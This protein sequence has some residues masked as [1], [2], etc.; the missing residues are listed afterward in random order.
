MILREGGLEFD[1]SD[2]IN[3]FKFDETDKYSETYHGLSHCMKAVDFI[4]ELENDY[5]L[6]EVKDFHDPGQYTESE[7]FK[8]LRNNLKTKFRDT[9][10][11]RFAEDQLKNFY[12]SKASSTGHRGGTRGTP[13]ST[14]MNMVHYLQ[15]RRPE[16]QGFAFFYGQ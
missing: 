16:V 15:C 6:V 9:L 1:F 11:Y 3:G 4:V 10:L 7:S 13:Q 14:G 5:L 2:A 12:D 8:K